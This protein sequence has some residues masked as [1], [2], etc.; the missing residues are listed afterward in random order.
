MATLSAAARSKLPSSAFA[1]P[2]TR[3]YPIHDANHAR[4]ALAMV[5]KYGSPA[6]KAAVHAKVKR[7]YPNIDSGS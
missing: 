6:E 3:S 1:V 7:K 4:L 5:S 2:A